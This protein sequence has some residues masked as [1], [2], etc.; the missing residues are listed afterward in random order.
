MQ[1]ALAN[2]E[3]IS[4]AAGFV[5]PVTLPI[6]LAG[7][8]VDDVLAD[9]VEARRALQYGTN[10]GL[11][12]LREA[13]LDRFH[14]ADQTTAAETG[15]NLDRLVITA[16]S[17]ELLHLLGD[18]LFDPGDIVLCGAPEYFVFLGLLGNFSVRGDRRRHRRRW[19]DS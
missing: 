8:A 2:P 17:N 6:E 1:Q 11:P 16:G 7:A 15:L 5:D 13:L 19:L 4:L 18:T 3:L 14:A 9:P 12:V 10:A